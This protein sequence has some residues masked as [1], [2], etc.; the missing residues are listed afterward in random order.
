MPR[1]K[2]GR[3]RKTILPT[4]PEK[5]RYCKMGWKCPVHSEE[6]TK[7]SHELEQKKRRKK[8]KPGKKPKSS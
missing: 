4:K 3:L 5:C 2:Y 8:M 6:E 7:A 1:R